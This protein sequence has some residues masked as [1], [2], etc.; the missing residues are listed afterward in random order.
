MPS[1]EVIDRFVPFSPIDTYAG[2]VP[3]FRIELSI[4]EHHDFCKRVQGRVKDGE[5][6]SKPYDETDSREFHQP[7][8]DRGYV[9]RSHLKDGIMQ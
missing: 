9:E 3:P 4:V 8:Q 7:F 2:A 6:S 1:H 5:E